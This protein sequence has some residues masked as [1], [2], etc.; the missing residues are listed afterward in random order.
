[1]FEWKYRRRKKLVILLSGRVG[2]SK[3]RF[4]A[5]TENFDFRVKFPTRTKNLHKDPSE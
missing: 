4:W 1:M 3:A 2:P 5:D